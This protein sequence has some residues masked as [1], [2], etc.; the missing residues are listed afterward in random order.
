MLTVRYTEKAVICFVYTNNEVDWLAS[1]NVCLYG[2][3]NIKNRA[4][5]LVNFYFTFE[6][7][8]TVHRR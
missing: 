7:I 5:L 8:L 3:L 1:K 2:Y 4:S 6:V